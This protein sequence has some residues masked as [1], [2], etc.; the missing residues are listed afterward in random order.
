VCTPITPQLRGFASVI[1]PVLNTVRWSSPE[2]ALGK[3]TRGW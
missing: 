3:C 2:S 1:R